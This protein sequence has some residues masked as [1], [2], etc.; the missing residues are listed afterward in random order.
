MEPQ[1]DK[2]SG[3]RRVVNPERSFGVSVGAVCCGLAALL[4]WR[5]QMGRAEILSAVGVVLL[6]GGLL[7]PALLRVPAA[8]WWKFAHVLGWINTRVLLSLAF[9]VVLLPTGVWWRVRGKDPLSRRRK[10]W[11]GWSPHPDRYRDKKHYARMY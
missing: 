11:A 7:A 3:A 10:A 6:A 2:E 8:L 9:I 4:V 1:L 5:G